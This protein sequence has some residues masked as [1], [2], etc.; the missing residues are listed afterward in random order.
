[1]VERLVGRNS[2]FKRSVFLKIFLSLMSLTL[3]PI[4]ILGL[5]S[6]FVFYRSMKRQSD[7]FDRL[8]LNTL[9]LK[10]DRHLEEIKEILFRYAL[11]MD[12]EQDNYAR[13]LSVVRELGGIAGTNDFVEDIFIYIIDTEQ[14][15]TQNGLYYAEVFFDKVYRYTEPTG[16][17]LRQILTG[18]NSFFFLKTAE[19][20]QDSFIE[21]R[22][23]TILNSVPI[24]EEPR[25]NLI[26]LV[27]E[28]S[29]RAT[30]DISGFTSVDAQIAIVNSSLDLIAGS[31]D[32][33]LDRDALQE[34][35]ADREEEKPS[36]AL[37]SR[38]GSNFVFH[39]SVA[40]PFF[41][42]IGAITPNVFLPD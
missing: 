28:A 5:T 4:F 21:K 11:F 38:L 42:T 24:R 12:I 19:V 9:S 39:K 25:A 34:L 1:M 35:L 30:F 33:T 17:E 13:L 27:D 20:I 29:L 22:Y 7:D 37:G 14:V 15:L 26:V 10:I 16:S 18:Q 8:I 23:L 41:Q 3:I 2:R 6:Y 31:I 40:P 32:E 36:A